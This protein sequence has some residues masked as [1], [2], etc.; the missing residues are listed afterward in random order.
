MSRTPS[1][2]LLGLA[3]LVGSVG[4][5]RADEYPSK[6]ITLV[7]PFSAGG[8]TDTVA[9]L[10]AQP[11]SQK[12]GQTVIIENVGGAGGTI[13]AARVARATPDG[14]TIFL[15][16]IGQ[17]T[18]ATLYK[19]LSYNVLTDFETV[20]LVTPVPMTIIAKKDFPAKDIKEFISYVKAN[21]DKI[22][23]GNAGVGAASHLCGM[24]FMSA[25]ETQLTT[26]SYKG[27]G[28]A[29]N[30]LLG[31]VFDFMCDQTTNT[32]C[33]IKG[34]RVKAYA[35]T[36]RTRVPSLP[37]LPTLDESGLKG[38]EVSV[39]HGLY[40]PKGTPQPVIDKLS[41]ALQVALTDPTVKQRFAELGTEPEPVARAT[42]AAHRA[43]LKA[44]VEK[45]A[46]V[47]KKAGVYAD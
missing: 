26:V 22:T 34:G 11:M 4:A 16:H 35:V 31:G 10:I 41:A 8:P 3:L 36:S 14:Y 42:P 25:I 13:A 12:L 30:D 1:Y 5:V 44:E 15:H 17:A 39:W 19:N 28:P 33:P 21:K 37:D 9:R 45:W 2:I 32:T 24:L 46:P 20:G 38:F 27:T 18:S 47:I 43:H 7:V 29:M 23:Y 40:A 6:V